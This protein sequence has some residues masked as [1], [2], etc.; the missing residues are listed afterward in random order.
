MS[1][2]LPINKNMTKK[3]ANEAEN[4]LNRLMPENP[5]SDQV[6]SWLFVRGLID[7]EK[8]DTP[9]SVML[10]MPIADGPSDED[11]N[12]EHF[13]QVF[14]LTDFGKVEIVN[15]TEGKLTTSELTHNQ[16]IN[17]Y[18]FCCAYLSAKA[19]KVL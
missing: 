12:P 15:D 2:P 5:T 3:L 19:T 6:A 10:P 8:S 7:S 1:N 9:T 17:L 4:N 16:V 11:E 13:C 14:Q 18:K